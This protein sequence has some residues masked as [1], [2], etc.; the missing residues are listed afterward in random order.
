M[1]DTG[2]PGAHRGGMAQVLEFCA[3]APDAFV[4]ARNRDRTLFQP[5]G[6]LGGNPGASG[7]FTLNPGTS[8]ERD[9]H[10][11]DAL[12]VQLGDVL[13]FVSPSGGGRGDAFTRDPEAVLRDVRAGRVTLEGAK[14][15]YG[16]VIADDAVDEE[17][18]QQ[19][20]AGRQRR[21]GF[22]PGAARTAH[23]QRWDDAAY[24]AMLEATDRLPASWRAPVKKLLF[25]SVR[26]APERPAAEVIREAFAGY[27]ARTGLS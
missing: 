27:L 19:L 4:T 15:D 12:R 22:A 24:A 11:T 21:T 9:L 13:R 25:A 1:P 5:W 7:S 14:R 20:R 6:V 10:N 3:T 26:A 8:G 17:A 23:E 18:T 16:V 2:G